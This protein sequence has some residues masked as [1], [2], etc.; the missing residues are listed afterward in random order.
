M[1]VCYEVY[2]QYV[3]VG[4]FYVM[5]YFSEHKVMHG[6]WFT[7]RHAFMLC[8]RQKKTYSGVRELFLCCGVWMRL[9]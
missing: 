5:V 1:S 8:V 2:M 3:M 9:W 7:W 4:L 6:R